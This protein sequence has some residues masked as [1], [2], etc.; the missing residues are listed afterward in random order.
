MGTIDQLIMCARALLFLVAAFALCHQ[1]S[2]SECLKH[3]EIVSSHDPKCSKTAAFPEGACVCSGN[4]IGVNPLVG[5]IQWDPTS[6]ACCS[7]CLRREDPACSKESPQ[8]KA[9]CDCGPPEHMR[10]E[11]GWPKGCCKIDD[12]YAEEMR[13]AKRQQEIDANQAGGASTTVPEALPTSEVAPICDVPTKPGNWTWLCDCELAVAFDKALQHNKQVPLSQMDWDCCAQQCEA[14]R[15]KWGWLCRFD[16]LN[17]YNQA[18][19]CAGTA[20]TSGRRL[21]DVVSKSAE[22]IAAR[23]HQCHGR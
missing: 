22:N 14:A 12:N 10:T 23:A 8:G 18:D 13:N 6:K 16:K 5:G 2:T 1:A 15:G 20:P 9:A 11:I 7:V 19:Y 4:L 21:L 3:D 17:A